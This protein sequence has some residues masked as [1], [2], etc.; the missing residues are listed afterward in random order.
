M[1]KTLTMTMMVIAF[2]FASSATAE[3]CGNWVSGS[4]VDPIEDMSVVWTAVKADQG[5]G[6]L[7]VRCV[8][9][10]LQAVLISERLIYTNITIAGGE[11]HGNT[12]KIRIG[13]GAVMEMDFFKL[14]TRLWV[15]A[16]D[17]ARDLVKA[18][19][20]NSEKIVVRVMEDTGYEDFTFNGL[21]AAQCVSNLPCVK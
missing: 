12:F 9:G 3:R 13:G 8:D 5:D 6:S 1:M 10:N 20:A 18:L 21:G 7:G 17:W 4:T 14:D 2:L 15:T 19:K 11:L 16:G